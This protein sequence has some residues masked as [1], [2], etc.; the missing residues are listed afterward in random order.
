[1][2]ISAWDHL[3]QLRLLYSIS[4]HTKDLNRNNIKNMLI[5]SLKK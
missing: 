4:S 2:E 5:I 1:M 3:A